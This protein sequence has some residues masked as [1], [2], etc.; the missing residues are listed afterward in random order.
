MGH[1]QP[2]NHVRVGGS[3][4]RKQ[5]AFPLGL[6]LAGGRRDAAGI[7]PPAEYTCDDGP[8]FWY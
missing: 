3:F 5:P 4:F 6:P 7:N 2:T 8:L 1:K